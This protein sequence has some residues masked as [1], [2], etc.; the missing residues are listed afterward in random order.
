MR[1]RFLC[2]LPLLVAAACSDNGTSQADAQGACTCTAERVSYD[3]STSTLGANNVQDA[4]D[5]LAARPIP[6]PPVGPRI[7]TIVVPFTLT[8]QAPGGSRNSPLVLTKTGMSFLVGHAASLDP[9]TTWGVRKSPTALPKPDSP[10]D[11]ACPRR[12]A[13][14]RA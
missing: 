4:V 1:A 8:D 3:H 7:Q 6:E 2:S 14:P 13:R 10:A 9:P 11:T 12:S 5:E